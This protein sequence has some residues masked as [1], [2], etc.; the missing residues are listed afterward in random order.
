[1]F[2]LLSLVLPK[3]PLQIALRSLQTDDEQLQGTALEYLESVLPP[4]IRFRLWPF[5]ERKP[6]TSQTRPRNEI[7]A[8]LLRSHV[9]IMLN[10]DE[11]RRSSDVGRVLSDPAQRRV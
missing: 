5:L 2:T 3:E 8:D 4:Q 9:S 7:I 6:L 1:M 10:L 11:L